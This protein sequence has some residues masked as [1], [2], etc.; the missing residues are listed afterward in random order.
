MKIKDVK[1]LSEKLVVAKPAEVK[2]LEKELWIQFPK[3]YADYVTQLGEGVLGGSH[4][5]IY[6]PWRIAS[7]LESW[8]SRIDAFWLWDN[9]AKLLPKARALECV[10]L[11]DTT[12]GDELIFHPSRPTQLFVLSRGGD[13]IFDAGP[14]VLSA[15]EWMCSSGKLCRKFKEREFESF[16]SRTWVSDDKDSEAKDPP[17]ESLDEIYTLLKNWAKR[18]Q[19]NRKAN[20][21]MHK[22]VGKGQAAE[23]LFKGLC[24][25]SEE[26]NAGEFVACWELA[27]KQGVK[28]TGRFIWTMDENSEGTNYTPA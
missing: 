4:V 23:L 6:P 5:R 13:K 25:E 20:A 22:E 26:L 15:V 27:K 7:E 19:I 2:Q 14:D 24:L 11:G 16:D 28:P 10:I 18:H 8:R 3:F 9:G 21:T 17:G 12:S 1:I